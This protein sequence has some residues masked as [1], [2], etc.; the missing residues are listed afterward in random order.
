MIDQH[1]APDCEH[2][3][4][5]VG[6]ALHALEPAEEILVAAHLPDC[7]E[8]TRTVA[9]T[10]MVGATLGL[11]VPEQAPSAALEQRVLAVTSTPQVARVEPAESAPPPP[12][13]ASEPA[14]QPPSQPAAPIV[15]PRTP[16]ISL[17]GPVPR[18][19]RSREPICVPE[20]VK[21]ISVAVLVMAFAAAVV[22]L[23]LP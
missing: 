5:A 10:E 2:S 18:R 8:C 12:P 9:E 21:L 19:R 16:P 4:L 17:P 3:E 20:M 13:P 15:S 22:F 6:W 23:A 7:A 11:S 1:R 14:A